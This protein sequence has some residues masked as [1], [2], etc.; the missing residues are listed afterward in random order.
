MPLFIIL[1]LFSLAFYIYYKIKYVRT[2]KVNEK[3]WLSAKSSIALGLF[4]SIFGLNRIFITQ[5]TVSILI[6]TL[7]IIIG[8][9]SIWTGYKAYKY[10]LPYVLAES[11]K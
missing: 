8:S 10:Y 2:N 9:I 1:I 7:F 3:R 5:T 6:G 4:V 11:E